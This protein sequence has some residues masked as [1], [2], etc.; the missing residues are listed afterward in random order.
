[1]AALGSG[2]A[3]RVEGAQKFYGSVRALDGATFKVRQGSIA[4]LI[5][6]NGAGKTTL[7]SL[8][9]G[10]CSADGG[11][12]EVL[13]GPPDATRLRGRLS[14]L[15]QDALLGRDLPVREQLRFLAHH[16]HISAH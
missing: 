13:G 9:C 11:T 7:F 2:L 14:A 5:G 3:L 12:V 15:P 1:M 10:F 4:A 8:V 16:R 6:P